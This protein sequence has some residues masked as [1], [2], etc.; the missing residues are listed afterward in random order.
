[1]RGLL[2]LLA[3]VAPIVLAS[4]AFWWLMGAELGASPVTAIEADGTPT[5]SLIGPKA[6]WP[7]WALTPDDT[8][9]T[10]RAWFKPTPPR[11]ETGFGEI[12]F[13]GDGRRVAGAYAAKLR[14]EGWIVETWLFR[15][16]YPSLPPRPYV[17][18]QLEAR[19]PE[20][21]LRVLSA[22]FDTGDASGAGRLHWWS[23]T[24]V[25]AIRLPRDEPC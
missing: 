19:R 13:A 1:M 23:T 7:D 8:R 24:P 5:Q 11:P 2:L 15:S 12:A 3:V 4:P 20:G 16:T 6:P 21:D 18:C 22:G 14:N 17:V 10:V 25:D 9:L